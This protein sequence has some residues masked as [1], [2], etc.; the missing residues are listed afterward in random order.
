MA[1]VGRGTYGTVKV[2]GD[3]AIKKFHKLSH[4]VQEAIAGMYLKDQEHIVQF[5][6]ADFHKQKLMM[7]RHSSTLRKW[8][9]VPDRPIK[10]KRDVTQQ[11]LKGLINIHSL[12]LVHGDIKPGNILIDENPLV[13]TIADLGFISLRPFS[14]VERTAAPYRDK[15]IKS[16]YEHDV[17]SVAIILLEIY[18]ELKITDQGNYDQ[19]HD[20]INREVVDTN[21]HMKK[22]FVPESKLRSLLLSMTDKIHDLRPSV[23]EVYYELFGEKITYPHIKNKVEIKKDIPDLKMHMKK[24]VEE[25]KIDRAN[26]GYKALVLYFERR[27]MEPSKKEYPIYA[28]SMVF[29]LSSVFGKRCTFDENMASAYANVKVGLIIDTVEKL[30]LDKNTVNILMTP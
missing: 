22:Y 9:E 25:Y 17:Y 23:A 21:G 4:I 14:K 29:I 3:V 6:S 1:F 24:I 8:L 11:L 15:V 13:V 7:K 16:H 19:I 12:K 30:A 20:A 10:Q 2:K 5:I 28:A 27:K 26:R 18:G